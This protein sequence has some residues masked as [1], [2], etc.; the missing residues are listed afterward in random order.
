[1]AKQTI[2]NFENMFFAIPFYHETSSSDSMSGHGSRNTDNEYSACSEGVKSP[3]TC[4]YTLPCPRIDKE[5]DSFFRCD[6][7]GGRAD[8][9]IRVGQ[10]GLNLLDCVGWET[11]LRGA[12]WV[13][14]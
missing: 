13:H 1:M 10:A 3:G 12:D 4:A 2:V 8:E 5:R 6:D 9:S 11:V 14:Y 7:P